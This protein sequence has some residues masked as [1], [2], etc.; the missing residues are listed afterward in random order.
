VSPASFT[1]F[2]GANRTLTVSTPTP[3]TAS[4]AASLVLTDNDGTSTVAS[5]VTRS[6]NPLAAGSTKTI[7]GAFQTG[8]GRSFGPAES[9]T[10][11]FK[12]PSGAAALNLKLDL[13]GA[14]VNSVVAHL[15]DPAG[16]PVA[17]VLN[18][19]AGGPDTVLDPGI[20][21][22]HAKPRPGRWRLTLELVNPAAQVPQAYTLRASLNAADIVSHGVPNSNATTVSK[23]SGAT[24]HITIHNTGPAAQTYFIDARTSQYASM[25]LV[26]AQ[27]ASQDDPFVASAAL[28]L[29]S[30]AVPG[31]LA[32]TETHGITVSG[33]ATAPYTFDLMPLDSPTAINA[34]NDPDTE[35]NSGPDATVSHSGRPVASVL[36]AAFPT[37][38]GP[39]GAAGQSGQSVDMQ[40]TADTLGFYGGYT[41]DT[42]DPLLATVSATAPA[43]TPVTIPAGGHATVTLHLNPTGAVGTS[44]HGTLYVDT[45]PDGGAVGN[46]GFAD[47]SAAIPFKFKVGS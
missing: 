24:Q 36:W 12:V 28:P 47:V 34:P 20:Q 45:L 40:A 16:E 9:D 3:S 46:A 21:I 5:V 11:N 44:D 43:A 18:Q 13:A 6:V 17:T 42:G 26:V 19:H 14:P 7:R 23:G 22:I 39:A 10:Y 1:L 37:L 33:S 4:S 8:N 27:S 25:P 41:S 30:E 32:P 29:Q 2:P 38:I 15:S 31:W 35:S